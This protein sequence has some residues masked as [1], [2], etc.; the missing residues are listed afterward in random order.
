MAEA[1]ALR[2][3]II[4]PE[5]KRLHPQAGLALVLFGL[6]HFW[7]VSLLA[8]P[9]WIPPLVLGEASILAMCLPAKKSIRIAVPVAIV[10]LALASLC[11]M[12]EAWAGAKLLC[13]RLFS[14]SEAR[15]RYVYVQFSVL[16]QGSEALYGEHLFRLILA[17]M[18]AVFCI[19]ST[20]DRSGVVT[21]ILIALVISIEVYFGVVPD[22]IYNLSLFPCLAMALL[23]GRGEGLSRRN[24][25]GLLA[26]AVAMGFVIGTVFPG[27]NPALENRSERLRDR[28]AQTFESGTLEISGKRD[29]PNPI[30]K[31][32]LL[33]EED[34][35]ITDDTQDGRD[36]ERRL[37]Y[38]KEL[39]N[40]R[41]VDYTKIALLLLI[42]LALLLLP[43]LPFL[44]LD[45]QKRK[46]AAMRAA[47][48]APDCA[49]AIC[50]MF[51]HIVLCLVAF[52][53]SDDN[54]GFSQLA[55]AKDTRL[56]DAYA[57]DYYRAVMLWQE[58]A[59]SDHPMTAAQ[60][61]TVS[62]LLKE[63]ARLVYRQSSK[64][65]RFRLNYVEC[66]ILPEDML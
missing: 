9:G 35:N 1:G 26:I 27:V 11:F 36:Y 23:I 57:S 20:R 51:Q 39:S 46:A 7:L 19:L 37:V 62:S 6:L 18:G 49:Q 34:A 60:K 66:L 64:K 45:K 54:K 13:N 28:L 38:L 44:W 42:T 30:R 12:P 43:F 17:A 52:G 61:E 33:A 2:L 21:V 3:K 50:A 15:N 48:D 32:G 55:Q 47:F 53:I 10:A 5:K 16:D 65:M 41:P 22:A 14:L 31:E 40:P 29:A 8:L 58:A 24:G 59:Y 63:T 25:V 56:S 4:S